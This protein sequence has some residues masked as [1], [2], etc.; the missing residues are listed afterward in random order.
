M[1]FDDTFSTVPYLVSTDVPPNW[2]ILVKESESAS[3]LEF[4]LAKT[5]MASQ[6]DQ[7]KFS[8][9]PEGD[10]GNARFSALKELEKHLV[11]SEGV[12]MDSIDS[13][14]VQTLNGI[15][16]KN[17][18][19]NILLEPTLP[20]LNK[21]TRRKSNR[22]PKPSAKVL[23]S[24]DNAVWK[25]FRMANVVKTNSYITNCEQNKLVV[26]ATHC[27]ILMKSNVKKEESALV[28]EI[29]NAGDTMQ[30]HTNAICQHQSKGHHLV[31]D[32]HNM[33]P[34][35]A[36]QCMDSFN[37]IRE[38]SVQSQ[39]FTKIRHKL[40]KLNSDSIYGAV[41]QTSNAIRER[42][43]QPSRTKR[44]PSPISSARIKTHQMKYNK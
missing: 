25:M 14:G 3:K 18:N 2:S 35:K 23:G 27:E 37:H 39:A 44:H 22:V 31:R 8:Q 13:E 30:S 9:D 40:K 11:D 24:K 15:H 6:Q 38:G 28:E 43:W 4:D 33:R 10:I 42:Q 26:M 17:K 19:L 20:D 16:V 21:L 7:N 1:A 5:W 29:E 36:V 32:S 34:N 41:L 12:N